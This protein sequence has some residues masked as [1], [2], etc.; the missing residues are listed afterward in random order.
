MQMIVSLKDK[1][2]AI[3]L[4]NV[5]LEK[6]SFRD[7]ELFFI[8]IVLNSDKAFNG[9]FRELNYDLFLFFLLLNLLDE[10]LSWLSFLFQ[11]LRLL[12]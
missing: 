5:G 3:L 8:V 10:L 2:Q 9:L 6:D 7:G 1:R 11:F 4:I 12:L